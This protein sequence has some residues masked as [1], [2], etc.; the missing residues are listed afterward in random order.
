MTTGMR[1]IL[2]SILAILS[3][4][5]ASLSA[6]TC[7]HHAEPKVAENDCHSH[8]ETTSRT[9]LANAGIAFDEECTCAVQ[10]PSPYVASRSATKELRSN[11]T[12]TA[13]EQAAVNIEFSAVAVYREPALEFATD[14]FYLTALKS[15]LPSRAPP[16]L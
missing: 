9:E 1:H 13:A 12:S 15:L 11:D 16:R 4:G 7:S 2:M 6:C 3:L 5:A 14:P 10:Q 8:H